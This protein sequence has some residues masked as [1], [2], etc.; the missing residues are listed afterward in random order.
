MRWPGPARP[1]RGRGREAQKKTLGSAPVE[2]PHPSPRA[3]LLGFRGVGGCTP[4]SPEAGRHPSA[5]PP[6]PG[7]HRTPLGHPHASTLLLQ[8]P[9][10]CRPPP[11]QAR[12]PGLGCRPASTP[13]PPGPQGARRLGGERGGA[14][15]RYPALASACNDR[16]RPR[17][18]PPPLSQR[19]PRWRRGRARAR[20]ARRRALPLPFLSPFPSL[21]LTPPCWTLR[22]RDAARVEVL[23]A[24]A[25]PPPPR[26]RRRLPAR[27]PPAPCPLP[28]PP[29]PT[30]PPAVAGGGGWQS[31]GA[32]AGHCGA[33]PCSSISCRRWPLT[34][35]SSLIGGACLP[36]A[37]VPSPSATCVA[38]CR[39]PSPPPLLLGRGT[40]P[41][42]EG[43]RGGR[44]RAAPPLRGA[45]RRR[46]PPLRTRAP[47]PLRPPRAAAG[48]PRAAVNLRWRWAPPPPPP[49]PGAWGAAP[50]LPIATARRIVCLRLQ[51]SSVVTAATAAAAPSRF[52]SLPPRQSLAA[53]AARP[54][55]GRGG[56]GPWHGT[57]P[58]RGG[59]VWWRQ[60]AGGGGG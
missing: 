53:A 44:T 5:R 41:G 45:P 18:L 6:P 55:R 31:G 28:P 4:P 20:R 39:V 8:L 12:P 34:L 40:D 22:T 33:A 2:L 30:A 48:W 57:A 59:E 21:P 25:L 54:M 13:P 1:G 16:R 9:K 15:R 36:C 52:F 23:V 49:T 46:P 17:S 56:G 42:G 3:G 26:G 32:F 27:C 14:P 19:P 58:L 43:G 29:P 10:E 37:R 38:G 51:V 11:L 60:A 24:A 7:T 50:P 35:P 47:P